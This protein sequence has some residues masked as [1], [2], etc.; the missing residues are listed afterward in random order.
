LIGGQPFSIANMREVRKVA[1]KHGI[2]VLLDASLI[3][4]NAYF[5][6]QREASSRTLR[7]RTS[8]SRCAASST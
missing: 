7:S 2:M 1:D 5:I 4:E 3:G 6:K 8:C